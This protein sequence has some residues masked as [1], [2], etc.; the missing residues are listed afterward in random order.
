V[1]TDLPSKEIS[2]P[3]FLLR[4]WLKPKLSVYEWLYWWPFSILLKVANIALAMGC[5]R[6]G[7]HLSAQKNIGRVIGTQLGQ[8]SHPMLKTT[9]ITTAFFR[10]CLRSPCAIKDKLCIPTSNFEKFSS[11]TNL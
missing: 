10:G 9:G 1:A 2:L 11:F 8:T 3:L 4:A 6:K 5:S 7:R